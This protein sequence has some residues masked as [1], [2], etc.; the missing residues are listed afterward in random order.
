MSQPAAD[1]AAGP[2]VPPAKPPRPAG[3]PPIVVLSYAFAGAD[4]LTEALSVSRSLAC[5][6]GTGLIPLCH[7]AL[8]T[9]Q[10]ADDRSGPPSALAIKSVRALA[11]AMMVAIQARTGAARWCET[12][13]AQPA[14]AD[15]FLQVFPSTAFVCVHR[16][17]PGVLADGLAAH[18]WGLGSSPFWPHSARYPGNSV[19][20]I[21]A[22][23]AAAAR[24]LLDFEA[25]HPTSCTRAHHQ[26]I[27]T[28]PGAAAARIISRL[29]LDAGE[30]A[31]VRAPAEAAA[32]SAASMPAAAGHRAQA[33]Q[34]RPAAPG[35]LIPPE[36]R[37]AISRIQAEL[38]Y[39]QL[40]PPPD[41]HDTPGG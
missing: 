31:A 17:L 24:S 25:R 11:G 14:A 21:A 40:N 29:H 10:Q 8:A 3:G 4:L 9:W 34:P 26:H 27:A 36:L 2:A 23:W 1:I 20:A 15:S 19:A 33:S 35:Q 41:P 12:A 38:G 30:I 18:P 7:A 32:G 37:P 28:D 22:W 39:D 13:L 5:T 16:D 6:S